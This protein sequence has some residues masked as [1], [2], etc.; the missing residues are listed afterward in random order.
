M[1][2]HSD[3]DHIGY[4][5]ETKEDELVTALKW[6]DEHLPVSCTQLILWLAPGVSNEGGSSPLLVLLPPFLGP[7][8][9]LG[10][11]T[12][13]A[14][15]ECGSCAQFAV[16]EKDLMIEWLH[17]LKVCGAALSTKKL[18]GAPTTE[19]LYEKATKPGRKTVD[20][21]AS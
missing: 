3:R 1:A 13:C 21:V 9:R 11:I 5:K 10:G 12:W 17:A 16:D 14:R 4:L 7:G 8:F 19:L 2:P 18:D 15:F 20:I 6:C